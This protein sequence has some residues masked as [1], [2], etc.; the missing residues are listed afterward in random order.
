MTRT[1]AILSLVLLAAAAPLRAQGARQPTATNQPAPPPEFPETPLGRLGRELIDL[2]DRGDSAAIDAFFAGHSAPHVERGRTPAW[3]ARSL[4]KLHAQTGGLDVVRIRTLPDER[5]LHVLTRARR[6]EHWLGLE[7]VTSA[8]DPARIESA[9]TIPLD[10]EM[11]PPAP[12]PAGLASDAEVAGAIRARVRQLAAADRFSGVV[13]VAKGD[14][15]LVHEAVGMAD[16]ERGVLNT[17]E[18]R[19]GTTSVGKMFTGVAIAQLVEQGKLRFD[20]TLASVLPE[21]PNRE[22]ARRITI[23]E[24]LTHTAGV[25]DVFSS[26]RFTARRDFRSHLEMLPTFADAPL[27]FTPGTRFEYSNGGYAVLGA[28]VEKLS[29]QPYEDYLRDHVWGPAGMRHTDHAGVGR[30]A[31]RAVGYV[32]FSETDPLGVEPRRPNNS[33]DVG[34]GSGMLAAYGGGSYTAEDLFRFARALRTARLLRPETTAL[35][36]RGVVPTGDGPAKYAFGFY[37]VDRGGHRVVGHPGSN[38]DTGLDS[39]VEMA[40]DEGW[41]IV[42]LSNYDAPAGIRLSSAIQQLLLDRR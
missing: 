12:W 25:P 17:R 23:R 34:P 38:S 3:F 27:D 10:D 21:Y 8:S 28:I 31:D 18:T 20:D 37:D 42:V 24:L 35:V 14:S 40:W 19:F 5:T 9:M 33:F 11:Q 13:L 29:G 36:T 1:F 2:V 15:I 4:T 16:R 32:R 7:L 39:D 6:N 22:A 30:G 41:T 26:P